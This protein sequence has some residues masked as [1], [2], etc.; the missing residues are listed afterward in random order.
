MKKH[1]TPDEIMCLNF[2][3]HCHSY[4]PSWDIWHRYLQKCSFFQDVDIEMG[5]LLLIVE[6]DNEAPQ[7]ISWYRKKDKAISDIRCWKNNIVQN[8]EKVNNIC[9]S[10]QCF[11]LQHNPLFLERI[12]QTNY[13][14]KKKERFSLTL[15]M[16]K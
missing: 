4:W 12:D 6:T 15:T 1:S 13:Y 10:A 7:P 16:T 11:I 5:P 2:L 3:S 14:Y 9:L 8:I